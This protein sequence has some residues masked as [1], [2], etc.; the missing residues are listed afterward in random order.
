MY[1]PTSKANW[2]YKMFHENGHPENTLVVHTTWKDNKYLPDAYIQS[3][4]DMATTNPVYYKI[5][6][7]GEFA[8]L[9]KLV[10]PHTMWE[11]GKMDLNKLRKDN[12]WV[13]V[14]GSDF[15]YVNDPATFIAVFVNKKEK[16]MYVY[17]EHYEKGM[18]NE[19]IYK[20]ILNKGYAKE[21]ITF[22]SAEP[23]SIDYLK[24]LGIYRGR[25]ARKGK[26]SILNGIDFITQFKVIVHPNCTNFKMELENYTW[27]KDKQT[28]EYVN[29]PND[30]FNHLIDA[31]RYS[32]EEIMRGMKKKVRVTN[33]IF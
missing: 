27:K 7:L 8:T 10:F 14:F 29:I 30:N 1:N 3:L 23:K 19:D 33:R 31:W 5:Y 2:V 16:L 4:E 9:D 28:N 6:A 26:D 21:I 11:V 17:D 22:D 18:T 32:C 12:D 13:S 24:K 15:G 20:M 25:S